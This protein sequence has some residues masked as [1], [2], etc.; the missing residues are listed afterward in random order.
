M[1]S[2]ILIALNKISQDLKKYSEKEIDAAIEGNSEFGLINK[3]Q[4][5]VIQEVNKLDE[6]EFIKVLNGEIR[7]GILNPKRTLKKKTIAVNYDD[8]KKRIDSC[9][10]RDECKNIIDTEKPTKAILVELANILEIEFKSKDT[11]QMIIDKIV[12]GTI[13]AKLKFGIFKSKR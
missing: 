9:K 11:K 8:I 6:E 10:T 12:D 3:V 1:E 13:G 2:K 5:K 4:K 7:F